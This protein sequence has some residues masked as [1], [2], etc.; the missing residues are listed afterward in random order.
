[1]PYDNITDKHFDSGD[2]PQLLRMAV[3]AIELPKVRA[4]QQRG[5]A[6]GRLIG[7][8]IAVF[9]EQTAHGTTA[10]GKRRALYEQA[11][12]RLTPDG[13]LEVRA[14]IQSIGQG[15]ET[16]LAQ[17]AS[18]FLGVDA[19]AVH[20]K[21]GDTELSPYSSG[22]WGSRGIVWAGGATAR[23]CKELASRVAKIGAAMLQTNVE[24]VT[25]RDGGVYGPQGSVS[26]ADI[27]R[28]FYLAP[29]DLPGDIDPH[30]LE[31][32]QG[33]APTRLTGVHTG[34]VH[35]TVVA[36]DPET[37][38]VEILDYVVVEDAGVL[39][40][41]AI[42][43]GQI[44]GGT[45]QGIGSALFEEMPFDTRG[46]PLAS[47][48]ADYL[49]PSCPEVPNVRILHMQTPSPYTEFGQKGVGE[50]GAIGPA[51]AIANAV[52]DALHRYGVELCEIPITPPRILAALAKSKRIS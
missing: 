27:A 28:A 48:L 31:V 33:Y 24:Q 16:T 13:G 18:E 4:R 47:S 19:A 25:V 50:G 32:T 3:D 15:L 46:Q 7:L 10:D 37:G 51:A 21:L 49:L 2:Y 1:M 26:L 41:P 38:G 39:V 14:G 40:N 20:V 22:A 9:S 44:V 11:F 45:A 34:S 30:G 42:V 5:E 36:V 52:N 23:A 29:A 8:G 12:A 43:D 6:D 17:I 35:A